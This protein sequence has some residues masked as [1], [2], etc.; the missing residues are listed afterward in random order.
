MKTKNNVQKAVKKSLAIFA[1]LVLISFTVSAQDFWK[2]ILKN[3]TL[4]EMAVIMVAS[5]NVSNSVSE[6]KTTDI[7]AFA[8]YLTAEKEEELSLE[9]WMT[10][11]KLFAIPATKDE[12]NL[13][14]ETINTF[15]MIT[16]A[17][18]KEEKL[19]PE[20]WMMDNSKFDVKNSNSALTNY[21]ITENEE[22]ELGIE[23]WMVNESYW[24]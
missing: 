7:N 4:N 9:D 12:T 21:T 13:S 17:Q 18:V 11:E 19:E 6:N 3:V 8:P 10:N 5:N 16:S 22:Q 2:S 15:A 23:A 20:S 1:S 24:K 14:D